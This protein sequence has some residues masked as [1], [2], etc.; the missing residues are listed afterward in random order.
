MQK[1]AIP[2]S[3]EQLPVIGMGTSGTF[4]VGATEAE[5]A[6][7][8]EV[9][10]VLFDG[11]GSLIDTA[12]S[13]GRAETV[14]GDL[15]QQ[16]DW[17]QREDGRRL[18]HPRRRARRRRAGQGQGPRLRRELSALSEAVALLRTTDAVRERA[19]RCWRGHAMATR[20]GS[21]STTPGSTAP[22][23]KWPR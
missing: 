11:G 3:S 21:S 2:S 10:R 22:P 14:I 15:L 23:Q 19:G 16:G 8:V 17:R 12:P 20:P 9:L 1:R 18:L 5:R 6:P 13:Y 7:L 4:D